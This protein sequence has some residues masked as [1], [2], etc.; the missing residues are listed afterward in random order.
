MMI[1]LTWPFIEAN[2]LLEH[3]KNKPDPVVFACGFGPSG[4][5]HLGSY[6]E[7]LRTTMVMQAF[8]LI[9]ERQVKLI[10]F[11]DDLDALRKVPTNVPNQELLKT[12]IG[13]PLTKVPDPYNVSESFGQHNNKRMQAFLNQF[14]FEY[15]FMSATDTY[16]SGKFDAA[17]RKVALHNKEISRLIVDTLKEERGSKYSPFMPMDG[18][19]GKILSEGVLSIDIEQELLTYKDSNGSIRVTPYTGGHCKLQWKVDWPMRWMALDISYEMHGK[20]LLD[21]AEIGD[22]I[23]NM[24]GYT[25]PLHMMYELFLDENGEKISK[26]RGNGIEINDW[27]RYAPQE[28]LKY[29]LFKNP[30]KARKLYWH[31]IQRS[32]DEYIEAITDYNMIPVV[33][34]RR[35][36]PIWFIH[37]GSGEGIIETSPVNFDLLL[38]LV[39]IANTSDVSAIW[40]YLK[41]YRP[42]ITVTPLLNHLIIGAIRYYNEYVKPKKVY[43]TPTDSEISVLR[44]ILSEMANI[45]NNL[46]KY[47]SD[48]ELLMAIQ[49]AIY[50]IGKTWYNVDKLREYF[51]MLYQVIMGQDSGPRFPVFITVYGLD[52]FINLLKTKISI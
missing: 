19:T 50:E 14:G 49:N 13:F 22:K 46:A 17:I 47:G 15:E 28:S 2:R 20:D 45:K 42:N 18:H 5:P 23:A 29:F 32:T 51:K 8:K 24:L 48:Q 4:L 1:E 38:N 33:E 31:E 11:S 44:N 40:H 37:G 35:N 9:S 16:R 25:P 52:N 36:H 7:V 43:R 39:S 6:S 26:S 10:V 12:H 30:R 21:S 34:L 27:L 41:V 3:V